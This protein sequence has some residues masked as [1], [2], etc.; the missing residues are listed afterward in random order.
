MISSPNAGQARVLG[1]AG[2]SDETDIAIVT[3]WMRPQA[4]ID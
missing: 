3:K 1:P 4:L 2:Q